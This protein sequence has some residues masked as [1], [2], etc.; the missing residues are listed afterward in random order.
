M[1]EQKK[2]KN[3]KAMRIGSFS[4]GISVVVLAIVIAANLL[5]SSLPAWIIRP[6]TTSEGMF[7]I[8][9]T[10]KEIVAGLET[11]VTLYHI[12]QPDNADPVVQEILQRYADL[13][14]HIMSQTPLSFPNIPKQTSL[15][16]TASLLSATSAAL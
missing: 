4:I 8:G 13:S 5:V 9:D 2:L 12:T 7:T 14:S 10:T 15:Q 11:D 16:K 3:K 6:D 1:N